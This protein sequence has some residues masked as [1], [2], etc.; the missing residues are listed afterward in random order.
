MLRLVNKSLL[1][2]EKTKCADSDDEQVHYVIH[3]L[4][5]DYMLETCKD[6]AARHKKL[7]ECY[8]KACD[9]GWLECLYSQ[10]RCSV[11]R[12]IATLPSILQ[13]SCANCSKQVAPEVANCN[14]VNFKQ[15]C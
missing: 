7:V 2:M 14:G 9:R 12:N 1:T 3:N 11:A 5:L 15:I 8:K 6:I 10:I 13:C 4:Q